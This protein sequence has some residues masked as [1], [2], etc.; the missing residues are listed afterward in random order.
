M[1]VRT[2]VL[3]V[4]LSVASVG[5]MHA[6]HAHDAAGA[7]SAGDKAAIEKLIADYA[8][9]LDTCKATEY[10]DLFTADGAFIS[11]P[12]G[13][14]AGHEKLAG[15]VTSEPYCKPGAAGSSTGH[16]IASVS[17]QP[18]HDGATGVVKL[19]PNVGGHY[20]DVYAKTSS[21]WKFKS[22]KYVSAKEEGA[23]TR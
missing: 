5:V 17:I 8:H 19:P 6:Q 11:G 21:G 13:S 20:D 3:T 1:R 16:T 4:A 12:R 10:A 7:L 2:A 15:L 23:A 14:V 18:T 22:R 9:D